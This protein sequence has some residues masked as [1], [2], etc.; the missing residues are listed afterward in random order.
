[1]NHGRSCIRHLLRLQQMNTSNE[2]NHA[3]AFCVCSEAVTRA[4]LT[5]PRGSLVPDAYRHEAWVDSPIR[6]EEDDY[7]ISAPHM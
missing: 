1:M 5:V 4:M 3:D 6:V 7:N 2:P